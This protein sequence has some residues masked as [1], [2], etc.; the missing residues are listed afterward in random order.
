MPTQGSGAAIV[1]F[2]RTSSDWRTSLITCYGK[3]R[4]IPRYTSRGFWSVRL[5]LH[6]RALALQ[7][8]TD[9]VLGR[10][11]RGLRQTYRPAVV[12]SR[13]AY[14][15]ISCPGQ[16]ASAWDL[17]QHCPCCRHPPRTRACPVM[18]SRSMDM[19]GRVWPIRSPVPANNP[20]ENSPIR[21]P[22]ANSPYNRTPPEWPSGWNG[23]G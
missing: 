6:Y 19:R 14:N 23:M 7:H 13:S 1:S 10:T 11:T 12:T 16:R 22:A 20:R 21:C 3:T 9:V 18:Q 17:Q 5:S 8:E 15:L 4:G 2:R